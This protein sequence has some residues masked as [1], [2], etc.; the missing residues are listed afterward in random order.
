MNFDLD[1]I[2]QAAV[3]TIRRTQNFIRDWV[4]TYPD[5]SFES[6]RIGRRKKP[7]LAVDLIAED[8]ASHE[9]KTKLKAYDIFTI[10]EESLSNENLDLSA[11]KRLV[12]LMDMVDGTDLLERGL[13]NWCSAMVVYFPPERRIVASFVGIPDDSVYYATDGDESRP[14]RFLFHIAQGRDRLV[15][16]KGPSNIENLKSACLAFYGQKVRNFLSVAAH[17]RFISYLTEIVKADV[18][19][20]IYNLGGNPMMMKL[21]DGHGIDAV[22]DVEGQAPHDVVPG[23]FIAQKAK[24]YFSDLD[25]NAIDLHQILIRPADPQSRIR[26]LITSTE[27]LSKELQGIFGG[28]NIERM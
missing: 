17:A 1:L 4:S 6:L 18:S 9:L 13:S 7:L 8:Y 28:R 25:G 5:R 2:T 11:E 22:F 16:I 15:S 23:A 21:I 26:Y 24:A 20:R 19:A 14:S 27:R 10:G 3:K 12:V